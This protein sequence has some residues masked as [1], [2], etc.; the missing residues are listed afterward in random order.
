MY[1]YYRKY[2]MN[3]GDPKQPTLAPKN[4]GGKL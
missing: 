1:V 3:I 2:P 4:P